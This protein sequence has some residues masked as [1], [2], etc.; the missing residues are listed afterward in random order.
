MSTTPTVIEIIPLWQR[1]S[2]GSYPWISYTCTR[3]LRGDALHAL[4]FTCYR[5]RLIA[6]YAQLHR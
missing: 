4:I 2:N 6:S 1:I 5:F 3:T